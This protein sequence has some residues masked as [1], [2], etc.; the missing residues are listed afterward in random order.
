M[1]QKR[2]ILQNRIFSKEQSSMLNV[3][4]VESFLSHCYRIPD[5]PVSLPLADEIFVRSW[6]EKD[7]R[8]VLAFLKEEFLLPVAGDMFK[9]TEALRIFFAETLGGRIPVIETGSHADFCR[10]EALL[11]GREKVKDLPMTVNAFTIQAQAKAISRHRVILLGRAPYSNVPAGLLG[12]GGEDW[13]RRSFRLR[14]AHESAHYE[15]LRLFGGMQNHPLDEIAADAL[16]QLAAFGSF[17][18][19]RQRLFFG[20]TRNSG[21]CSG[22]LSY[23]CRGFLPWDRP[24]I[25]RAVD[26]ALD[27]IEEEVQ[28][29]TSSGSTR[30]EILKKL[31]GTSIAERLKQ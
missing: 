27:R 24:V 12:L 6:E 9:Q 13:L 14:L 15:M 28:G 18:A 31:A 10:M 26:Q 11:N 23:Y 25:C 29:L 22:R 20:L 7:G 30:Y 16:G 19:E 5:A 4:T 3:M 17:S 8:E 1:L 2:N 21:V